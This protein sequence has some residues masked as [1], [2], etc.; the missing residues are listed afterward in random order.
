MFS[1]EDI[2]CSDKFLELESSEIAYIKMDVFHLSRPIIRW[3]GRPHGLRDAPVWISGHSDYGVTDAIYTKYK[4]HTGPW[5]TVN[6]ECRAPTLYSVPLG[7]TNDC[8]DSPTHAILGNLDVMIEVMGQSCIIKN[9][10]YMNFAIHTYPT[11]RRSVF[12]M[13]KDKTWVT[14]E[15]SIVSMEG[16]RTFL[17]SIRNHK[18][19]LCPRGNGVDTHRLWETLY[20]GS[21]P[22]VKRHIAMEDFYD[23]PVCWI[24]DWTQV[25]ESFLNSEYDRIKATSWNLDKLKFSYWKDRI[26][27]SLF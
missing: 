16:R 18:F 22:I 8:A 5:Y 6:K 1:K 13:F 27:A 17:Q 21:I 23:L 10:V 4:M 24:D 7:I 3:R 14:H 26:T 2:L 19:V 15:E 11:E 25:T 9:L 12:D 20:M